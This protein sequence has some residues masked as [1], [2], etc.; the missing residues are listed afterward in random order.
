MTGTNRSRSRGGGGGGGGELSCSALEIDTQISS[1]KA[2]VVKFL[3]VDDVLQV[4]LL[5]SNGSVI[6][7]VL[8]MGQLAG[9]IASPMLPRLRECMQQGTEY[10]AIVTGVSGGQVKVRIEAAA[11]R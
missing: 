8:H 3:K 5:Q 6:V 9:G 7:S 2:E 11:S 4:A 10:I 1:P